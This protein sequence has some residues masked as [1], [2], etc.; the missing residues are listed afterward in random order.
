MYKIALAGKRYSRDSS[1]R[2]IYLCNFSTHNK[3]DP[4][5]ILDLN[6]KADWR[7]I[8]KQYFKLARQYHPDLNKNDEVINSNLTIAD[9]RKIFT[10]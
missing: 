1:S 10:G 9:E 8:K 7:S 2:F 6:R 4:Y 5:L 3:L